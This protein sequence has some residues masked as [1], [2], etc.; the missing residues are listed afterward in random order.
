MD[1][2]DGN[3]RQFTTEVWN[4][5]HKVNRLYRELAGFLHMIGDDLWRQGGVWLE[6]IIGGA[7]NMVIV[8]L[9]VGNREMPEVWK[10]KTT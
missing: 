4:P 5:L 9:K 1:L 7:C 2:I 8:I 6:L 10:D 3:I